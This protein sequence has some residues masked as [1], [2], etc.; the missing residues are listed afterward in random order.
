MISNLAYIF[1]IHFMK[2]TKNSFNLIHLLLFII[3]FE[4]IKV[5][6]FLFLTYLFSLLMGDE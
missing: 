3:S 5:F 4:F 6:T 2:I 1:I